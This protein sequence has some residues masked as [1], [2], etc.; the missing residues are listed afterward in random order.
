MTA[1]TTTGASER[2]V[3]HCPRCGQVLAELPYAVGGW[4]SLGF[5]AAVVYVPE[6][7]HVEVECRPC[8]GK[9]RW[10]ADGRGA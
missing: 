1:V 10:P 7:M 6:E 8:G 4:R 5:P 2:A 3:V 9:F